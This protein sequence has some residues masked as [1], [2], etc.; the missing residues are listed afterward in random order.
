MMKKKSH[1]NILYLIITTIAITLA[2]QVFWNYKNYK[3]NKRRVVVEVRRSL[4]NAVEEYYAQLVKQNY[5]TIVKDS[6]VGKIPPN[7]LSKLDRFFNHKKNK[8]NKKR[9]QKFIKKK[10]KDNFRIFIGKKNTD[11]LKN[12]KRLKSIVISFKQDTIYYHRLDSL[13]QNQLKYRNINLNYSLQHLKN[14]KIVYRTNPTIN[15]KNRMHTQATSTFIKPR[16]KLLLLFE[17]PVIQI[18]YRS[19]GGILLSFLLS[20][21]IIASLF[22]LLHI[23]KKQKQ[24][25]LIKNDLINNIT[26]EFKTPITTASTAIEAIQNFHDNNPEKSKNY[27]EISKNQ[28]QKLHKMVEKLLETAILDS[29]KLILQKE[30]LNLN[31]LIEKQINKHKI[32]SDKDFYF[33]CKNDIWIEADTFHFENA[34]NNVID[35]AVK[36]GGNTIRISVKNNLKNIEILISD[37]GKGIPKPHREAIFDKFYRISKGNIHDVKGFGIGLYYTQQIIRKHKGSINLE[38]KNNLTIFKILLPYE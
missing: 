10:E 15:C 17:N 8:L 9:L 25:A 12:L 36:Y 11:S 34:I 29:E 14:K 4:D 2:I 31:Q 16:E 20:C 32:I 27:L 37:N 7:Y 13:F 24:L 35:N 28:L 21:I 26:H 6:T 22:Y 33:S 23:I 18:L 5:L 1:Y 3:Q 38:I 30:S 19:L